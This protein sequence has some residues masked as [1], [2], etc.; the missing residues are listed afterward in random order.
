[1]KLALTATAIAVALTAQSA[2]Q[3]PSFEISVESATA[4]RSLVEVVV[5]ATNSTSFVQTG[6]A[7]QCRGRSEDG[8][9]SDLSEFT[10]PS[11]QIG[12][13]VYRQ[14]YLATGATTIECAEL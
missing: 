14:T 5:R 9:V 1:M 3:V 8:K 11:V 10:L 13:T 7:V 6:V 4:G 2:A 12:E